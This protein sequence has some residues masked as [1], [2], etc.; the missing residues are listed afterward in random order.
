MKQRAIPAWL[1]DVFGERQ[2][3]AVILFL[4]LFGIFCALTLS[5]S[6]PAAFAAPAWW[7]TLLALLLIADIASG[8]IANFTASTNR[9]YAAGP[10][11]RRLLFI[12]VHLHLPAV[13]LLLELDLLYA[14]CIWAYTITAASIVAATRAETQTLLG[15]T[16]LAMGLIVSALLPLEPT[17]VMQATGLLFMLKV[18]YSFGVDHYSHR[19]VTDGENTNG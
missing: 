15:G 4:L 13:A 6:D 3:I 18:V 11:R 14:I 17:P 5:L 2:S 7:R 16:L 12:A 8:C 1:H 10:R 19:S 9:H